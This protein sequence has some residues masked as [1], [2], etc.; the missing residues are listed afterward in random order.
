MG[1]LL[2]KRIHPPIHPSIL[3]LVSSYPGEKISQDAL[4]FLA[5]FKRGG[6]YITGLK[7]DGTSINVLK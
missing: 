4:D 5:S 3:A 1:V 7:D 6:G 2:T